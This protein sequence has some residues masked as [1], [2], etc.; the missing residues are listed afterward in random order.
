M[1]LFQNSQINADI[2]RLLPTNSLLK[3]AAYDQRD[4]FHNLEKVR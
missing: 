1:Q 3:E 2:S 4:N